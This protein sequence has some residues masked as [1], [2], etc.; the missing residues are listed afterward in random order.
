MVMSNG[1][2]DSMSSTPFHEVP[3]AQGLLCKNKSFH[4]KFAKFLISLLGEVMVVP[5]CATFCCLLSLMPDTP[6][7]GFPL[8]APFE[9]WHYHWPAPF[10]VFHL[11][12]H[13]LPS[14]Q[15]STPSNPSRIW[16]SERW[17][18]AHPCPLNT[19]RWIFVAPLGCISHCFP[20]WAV[21]FCDSD[22][23]NFRVTNPD[24]GW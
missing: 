5:F 13:P 10:E 2:V 6:F 14:S 4:Q 8:F 23:G 17:G 20:G 12:P 7:C 11:H 19:L 22:L 9:V 3:A 21:A 16:G 18:Y 24:S 1:H 15:S